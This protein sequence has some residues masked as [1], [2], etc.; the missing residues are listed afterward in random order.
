MVLIV[1]TLISG[2]SAKVTAQVFEEFPTQ[3]SFPT[4]NGGHGRRFVVHR[5]QQWLPRQDW[6]DNNSGGDH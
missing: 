4:Y 2:W 5:W 3:S 6:P 1:V